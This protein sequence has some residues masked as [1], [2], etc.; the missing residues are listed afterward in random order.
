MTTLASIE[1]NPEFSHALKLLEQRKNLFITGRAGTGKSTLLSYFRQWTKRRVVVLAPTGVAALNVGGQTIHSFFGFKPNVT[2]QSVK[3]K[4]KK[5]DDEKNIYNRIDTLVIDEI[6]MVRADLLDCVDKFLRLNGPEKN[7][8]FGGIQVVFIGDLYQLPPVVT[9]EESAIFALH[10]ATP[11]FFSA[12]VM[13]EL[14]FELVE[15]T[16]VYRQKNN[17][18]IEILNAIR[19]R[20][21]TAAHLQQLNE[22]CAPDFSPPPSELYISLTATNRR[23]DDLNARAQALLTGEEKIFTADIA[24][25]FGREYYPTAIDLVLKEGAQ[26][27]LLNNDVG[28]RWVNGSVG[29][30][31]GFG[32]SEESEE[33]VVTVELSDGVTV[34]VRP[35]T[36]EISRYFVNEQQQLEAEVM[37]TFTQY[38]LRL[39]FAITVHKAQGKTFEKVIIDLERGTF[40]HGQAY[41]ALSRCTALAGMVLRYPLELKHIRMDYRVVRWLTDQQYRQAERMLDPEERRERIAQ[42]IENQEE[43]EIIYLKAKDEKSERRI[44]PLQMKPMIYAGTTFLGLEAFCCLRGEK[45]TFNVARILAVKKGE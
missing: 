20:S 6:S 32:W 35:Y 2:L 30:I 22:R 21:V 7:Q 25:D 31:T 38:P 40:A 17:Q 42:A 43:L 13:T 5:R 1:I 9:T 4:R 12:Q 11:Y 36:W 15:L 18:F 39:A 41:V 33:E 28:G 3:A 26:V 29:R 44:K 8:P 34:E 10:Y 16:K 37:G 45:R 19:N 23:A 14:D 27:M 24:G